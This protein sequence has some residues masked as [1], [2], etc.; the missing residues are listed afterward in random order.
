MGHRH[1]RKR[2]RSRSRSRARIVL[3]EFTQQPF[4]VQPGLPLDVPK[5]SR[6]AS[7]S[8]PDHRYPPRSWNDPSLG[9]HPRAP[10][11]PHALRRV[12]EGQKS[13]SP[14][15][16]YQGVSSAADTT[17]SNKAS[18]SSKINT[19]YTPCMAGDRAESVVRFLFDGYLDFVDAPY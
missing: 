7:T 18:R 15:K 4:Y 3:R 17:K 6:V 14:R 1:H 8:H 13:S 9:N 5:P 16:F 11:D 2:T 19:T 12:S 10:C